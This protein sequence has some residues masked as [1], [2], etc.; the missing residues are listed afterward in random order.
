MGTIAN[1]VWQEGAIL[2]KSA[3]IFVTVGNHYKG[4]ERLVIRADELAGKIDEEMIIQIGNTDYL[5]KNAKYFKF[6]SYPEI[7]EYNKKARLVI[8]HAGV[9]SIITALEQNTP[10][11]IVPRLGKY[12]EVYD[13]HQLEIAEALASDSRVK[14][15]YD[16][17]NLIEDIKFTASFTSANSNK[18]KL[19]QSLKTHL[20]SLT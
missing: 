1:E 18:E 15:A 16:T 12:G 2:G 20:S 9:G 6:C 8:S 10:V 17:D 3:M 19:I 11:I 14:V 7:Q 4:F 13:D 5:P